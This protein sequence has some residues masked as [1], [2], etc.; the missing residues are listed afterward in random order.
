MNSRA[1]SYK[2]IR[3]EFQMIVFLRWNTRATGD[4]CDYHDEM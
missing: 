3:G 4:W 2:S 1:E